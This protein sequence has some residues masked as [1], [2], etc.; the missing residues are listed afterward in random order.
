MKKWFVGMVTHRNNHCIMNSIA[1][2]I[3]KPRILCLILQHSP[4]LPH[5]LTHSLPLPSPPSLP[6]FLSLPPSLAMCYSDKEIDLSTVDLSKLKVRDLRKILTD[7][8]EVC[9]GCVEKSEF[10]SKIRTVAGLKSELWGVSI[11]FDLTLLIDNLLN[12]VV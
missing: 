12:V 6:P 8:G 9:S 1:L 4:S 10:V 11:N 5:S 3:G 7:M 2:L